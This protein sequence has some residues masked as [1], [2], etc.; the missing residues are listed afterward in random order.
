MA[1]KASALNAEV[2]E[3]LAKETPD[4]S[5]AMS[6]ANEALTIYKDL[7]DLE[8]Q[9]EAYRSMI[10]VKITDKKTEEARQVATDALD[11][12]AKASDKPGQ[13]AAQ[14]LCAEACM[15][16][17]KTADALAAAKEALKLARSSGDKDGVANALEMVVAAELTNVEGEAVSAAT[18]RADVYKEM[19]DQSK[20]GNAMLLLAQAYVTRI[21]LKLATCA[22][23]SVD[24]TM[25]ALQ[26][27]KDA[28]A[29]L[30]EAGDR[31]GMQSAMDLMAR[32]L[33]YNGVPAH[34]IESLSDPED[35]FQDVLSGKY[36]TPTNGLPANPVPKNLKLEEVIPSSKQ[37]DRSKFSWTN[38]LAGYCYTLIW[39]AAKDRQ[40][41]NKQNRGSY[42]IM[43]L[44]TNAKTQ[45]LS[46]AFTTLSN[47]AAERNSSMV[48]YM[49]SHNSAQQYGTNMIT[50]TATLAAMITARLSKITFV[51]FGENHVDWT[52]TRARQVNIYPVTL[53]LIR[54]CRIEAPTVA[55]GY[56]SGDACSWVADPAPL[57]ESMFDTLES[58]ECEL[59][60]K[61][62]EAFAPLLIHRAM[63]DGV[64]YVKPK[65][66]TVGMK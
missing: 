13:V 36:S 12:F 35:V 19:G 22:I 20:Q 55:I 34:I 4:L 59:M 15:S 18:E 50:Q 63:D 9:M 60:Y 48:V 57:I 62:G 16:T 53:A 25:G 10:S 26:S 64:T 58:D 8:G 7:K 27:A 30:A 46:T 43:T 24:D 41:P 31:A 42:D 17:G 28:H 47:D 44:N 6:K 49:T 5:A 23:A 66:V 40:I 32:V 56:V 52:D 61:R 65:R 29:L 21:G 33:M 39:Q 45:S 3:L 14:L 38:P 2:A 11:A 51:Q 1:D 54:S 37:L